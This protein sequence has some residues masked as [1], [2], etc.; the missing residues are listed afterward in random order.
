M[1]STTGQ[2]QWQV[3]FPRTQVARRPIQGPGT[4][5]SARV[6]FSCGS[7]FGEIAERV[8]CA[9]TSLLW[10]LF[11][12]FS[13]RLPLS[14]A[15]GERHSREVT[16]RQTQAKEEQQQVSTPQK[17]SFGLLALLA[18]FASLSL[19]SKCAAR[20]INTTRDGIPMAEPMMISL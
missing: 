8:A 5:S 19:P 12:T 10:Y 2:G 16:K 13:D 14:S 1:G 3:P 6:S 11:A 18:H 7:P 4:E 20:T 15:R 9:R 17:S